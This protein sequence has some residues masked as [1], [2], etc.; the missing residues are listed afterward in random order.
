MFF[1]FFSVHYGTTVSCTELKI[2][3]NS[4]IFFVAALLFIF[5]WGNLH[6]VNGSPIVIKNETVTKK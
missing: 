2:V 1:L 3:N 5:H 4:F 6:V